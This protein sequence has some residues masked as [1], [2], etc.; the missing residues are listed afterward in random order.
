M[1]A[2]LLA[3]R[4]LSRDYGSLGACFRA[5]MAGRDE[6]VLPALEAFAAQLRAA[7]DGDCGHLL[8]DPTRGSAC[9]RLNL[10]L[11]WLVRR[12]EVDP[13]GWDDVPAAKLVVPVDTHMHRI[14]AVIGA[15]ARA[16]ADMTT[17]I[18]ITAAFRSISPLDPV[19]YDFAL[20]RLG[21]REDMDLSA[22][23]DRCNSGQESRKNAAMAGEHPG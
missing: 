8:P 23:L 6:T 17:A 21:I 12:D 2:M 3:A 14:A 7:A 16:A 11:R 15:T 1:A 9:K 19:R 10:M 5:A 18:E 13:G 22:L 4:R 20:T